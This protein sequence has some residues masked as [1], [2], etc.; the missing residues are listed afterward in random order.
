MDQG[1]KCEK[2]SFKIKKYLKPVLDNREGVLKTTYNLY[3]PPL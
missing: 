2:Q 3:P 1:L